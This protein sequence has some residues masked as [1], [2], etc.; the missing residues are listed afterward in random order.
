MEHFTHQ[1]IFFCWNNQGLT[2]GNSSFK[3]TID[4]SEGLPRTLSMEQDSTV[5]AGKNPTFDFRPAGFPLPGGWRRCDYQLRDV[6]SGLLQQPDGNGAFFMVETF[7]PERE[8]RISITYIVYPALPVMAVECEICSAVTPL[9][10]WHERQRSRDGFNRDGD[11]L[12]MIP[13][14]LDLNNFKAVRAVEFQMRTDQFDEPV[15]EHTITEGNDIY[16]NIL[17]AENAEKQQF[18]FL[19]EAPPSMERRGCEPGDFLIDGSLISSLGSGIIPDDIVPKKVLHTNRIVCGFAQDGNASQL[20]KQY[21]RIRQKTASKVYG[22]ITVNP[23]GCGCFPKLLNE[24]FLKDEITA[25]ARLNADTYQID[26]GYQHGALAD[27]AVHNRKLDQQYWSTRLDLLPDGFKPLTKLAEEVNVKLSLWFAPSFNQ[28]YC[29]WQ[30]SCDF[31]LDHWLTNGFESFKLDS[32]VFNSYTAEENFGKM[33][34]ALYDRSNGAVT[35]NLDVTSGTRGGL[36][37]FAEYGLIFLENRY[38]CHHWPRN[39]YQPGNTLDNLWNIA[40]YCRIQNLQIEIPDPDNVN[41]AAYTGRGSAMPTEYDFPYWAM[42]PMFASPLLW[43]AP[44][45]LMPERAEVLAEI[46]TIQKKYRANWRDSLIQPVGSRPDGKSIAG[47]YADSGYLLVFREKDAAPSAKLDL[48]QY[49][50]AEVLYA[51]AQTELTA[52]GTITMLAPGSAALLHLK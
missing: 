48:P 37:K 40:K 3:R 29:D 1:D 32:V 28:A 21:L 42:I 4:W 8:L 16:G 12:L 22:T 31:L 11:S 38:C 24:P 26:D 14:S 5:I 19:Q 23:W 13:E 51:T 25:S 27:M 45:R 9:I 35:V 41:P 44:S 10:Y 49:E 52:D 30:E 34:K 17:I 20:I 43:M 50:C 7:E 2:L 46:M 36:L 33:L 47:F 6:R 18:F 39:P 15:L